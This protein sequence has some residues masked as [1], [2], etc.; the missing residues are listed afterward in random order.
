MQV[1]L[2]PETELTVIGDDLTSPSL[3]VAHRG[4]AHS[5]RRP[6]ARV[7]DVDDLAVDPDGCRR[8]NA[9]IAEV[10]V[11]SVEVDIDSFQ[12]FWLFCLVWFDVVAK[13]RNGA[14]AAAHVKY[15]V[16]D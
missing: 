6:V 5:C 8:A 14:N 12:L 16:M 1:G 3:P 9:L 7:V 4:R 11:K 10:V 2:D 15:P 13:L